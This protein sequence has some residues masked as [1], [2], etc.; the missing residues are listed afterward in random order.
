MK[1]IVVVL[2]M[3]KINVSSMNLQN[4]SCQKLSFSGFRKEQKM[5]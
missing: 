3:T 4:S 1:I 2:K 5:T